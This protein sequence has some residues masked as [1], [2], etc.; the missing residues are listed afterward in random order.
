MIE[1]GIAVLISVCMCSLLVYRNTFDFCIFILYYAN[2]LNSFI[3][4]R[5]VFF[6]GFLGFSLEIFMTSV[7]RDNFIYFFLPDLYPFYLLLLYFIGQNI[8]HFWMSTENKYSCH[9]LN[10]SGKAFSLSALNIMLTVVFCGCSLSSC[11][12]TP[13]VL[14]G[15][16]FLSWMGVDFCQK[17][18]CINWYE[19]LIWSDF[20]SYTV[21]LMDNPDWFSN[22]E[23]S[24]QIWSKIYLVR[25]R[26]AF[27][28]LT[29]SIC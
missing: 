17:F 8:Q 12:C 28:I 10:L 1:N 26:T 23:P 7:S 24:L 5:R 29:Y 19:H 9:F 6:V 20:L 21:N 14:L 2:L 3:S 22:I 15:W 13:L 18:F 27:Y 16:E 25:V 11:G 4:S